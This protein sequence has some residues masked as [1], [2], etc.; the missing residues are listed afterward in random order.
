MQTKR[1]QLIADINGILY[2]CD[3][4]TLIA[5][6]NVLKRLSKHSEP[7]FNRLNRRTGGLSWMK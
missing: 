6:K 3:S 1:Q 7:R 5:F 4:V 2:D